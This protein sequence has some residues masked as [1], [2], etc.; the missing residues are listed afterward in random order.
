MRALDALPPGE[1]PSPSNLSFMLIG[2]GDTPNGGI[3]LAGFSFQHPGL[4]T[5]RPYG[6]T[7]AADTPYPDQPFTPSEYDGLANF[8]QYPLDIVADLNALAGAV[9]RAPARVG[10]SLTAR[11]SC[12]SAVPLA[13][14]PGYYA[15]GGVTQLLYM[16]PEPGTCLCWI[17]SARYS[18]RGPLRWPTCCNFA[19]FSGCW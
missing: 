6:A 11:H 15:D 19:R 18:S 4:G 1:A 16:I 3:F 9:L 8:P 7:A 14:S 12:Q 13:T 17:L 10:A 2:N 5:S